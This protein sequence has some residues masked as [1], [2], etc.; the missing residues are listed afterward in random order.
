[1]DHNK[2]IHLGR[3]IFK[4]FLVSLIVSCNLCSSYAYASENINPDENS[5]SEAVE[6]VAEERKSEEVETASAE[7]LS[8]DTKIGSA[9][10]TETSENERETEKS[11]SS[12]EA[13][14]TETDSEVDKS[15]GASEKEKSKNDSVKEDKNA[16]QYVFWADS[17]EDALSICESK[18]AK[19]LDFSNGVGVLLLTVTDT[20]EADGDI[21]LFSTDD[22]E[23]YP[24]YLYEI[25]ATEQGT[26]KDFSQ[27]E[28]WHIPLLKIEESLK[29][30]T[31]SGVNVGIVDSGIDLDNPSL[32]DG[33]I[34]A[35]TT[36]PDDAY[37]G[38]GYSIL[39]KG[40]QD[41]TGHGT[42]VAGLIRANGSDPSVIGIAP[43]C[44]LISIK[45]L[46]RNGNTA[47][48]YTSW[49]V[50]ALI[51]A[52]D[53]GADIVNLSL[54]GSKKKDVF[55]QEAIEMA[56]AKGVTVVCA[57]G[58]YT[59]SDYQ[60]NVDYPAS[61][62][63]TIC[64]TAVKVDGYDI[65]FDSSYS[66]YGEMATVCA[67]G[68]DILSLE[69]GNGTKTMSGTSMACAIVSGEAALLKSLD[70]SITGKKLKEYLTKDI[71][72]LGDEGF[73]NYYGYGMIQPLSALENLKKDMKKDDSD[74][75]DKDKKSE[76]SSGDSEEQSSG[77]SQD[78]SS[79][80]SGEEAPATKTDTEKV[81]D[82]TQNQNSNDSVS[83]DKKQVTSPNSKN[84]KQVKEEN[85][86]SDEPA[87]EAS[88]QE[89]REKLLKDLENIS[90]EE[91]IEYETQSAEEKE[92]S[93]YTEQE[94]DENEAALPD[95]DT[96]TETL[97]DKSVNIWIF[98]LPI[99][100]VIC[101]LLIIWLR[102]R[103]I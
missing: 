18:G 21:K 65:V 17:Y 4:L 26:N 55:M 9:T 82:N 76:E 22:I 39:Y 13:E 67:P 89:E 15:E 56:T 85:G 58:N 57:A 8:E 69:L 24:N 20:E 37:G 93:A 97:P 2:R 12:S 35:G 102:R 91:E 49:I 54:G 79:G 7:G 94:T 103:H 45:A 38:T 95:V 87:D 1:M 46:D 29:L 25:Q 73:D 86:S 47:T 92:I 100:A 59:G 99:L 68:T 6:I 64:V 10:D 36:I 101:V 5:V 11:E 41:F 28:Q 23:L 32:S 44:S 42:H 62:P 84:T 30:A 16:E 80:S 43:E 90:P 74:K 96:T 40:P 72:D 53:R 14:I 34:Y 3:F 81:S 88:Y 78:S 60:G 33:I 50:R 98:V 71:M 19:L 31:G 51:E 27:N 77:E 70:H 61:D 66:K 75:K 83:E 63:N 48:G 52:V